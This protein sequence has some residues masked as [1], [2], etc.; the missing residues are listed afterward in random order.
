MEG[1]GQ[2]SQA[3][4]LVARDHDRGGK[5]SM[6]EQGSGFVDHPNAA[7]DVEL[8]P[9]CEPYSRPGIY[10]DLGWQPSPVNQRK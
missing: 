2:R 1:E 4:T 9:P 7:D 5:L 8:D 3:R 6:A 10:N